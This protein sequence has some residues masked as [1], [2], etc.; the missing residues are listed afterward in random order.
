MSYCCARISTSLPLPSSPHCVPKIAHTCGS[1]L[2][3]ATADV[4]SGAAT[5]SQRTTRRWAIRVCERCVLRQ[6]TALKLATLGSVMVVFPDCCCRPTRGGLLSN[7]I[8]MMCALMIR[9]VLAGVFCVGMY[10]DW[11]LLPMI[12]DGFV[13]CGGY[14]AATAAR[15]A[16]VVNL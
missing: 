8:E 3:W 4:F 10:R 11:L 15:I 12:G 6:S 13:C 5:A 2:G 14:C 7:I 1:N 16:V 9:G